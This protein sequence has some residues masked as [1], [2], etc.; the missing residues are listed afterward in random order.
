MEERER[1]VFRVRVR[2]PPE[3][4]AGRI[5]H[6]K[7]GVRGEAVLRLD[8]SAEWPERLERRIPPDLFE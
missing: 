3:R 7:T 5:A 2:V 6:V 4:V 8:P 1:L